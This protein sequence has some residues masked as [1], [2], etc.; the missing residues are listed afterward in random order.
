MIRLMTATASAAL[1]AILCAC[2]GATPV[3]TPPGPTT[4]TAP[5]PKVTPAATPAVPDSE[6]AACIT[7][8]KTVCRTR[9]ETVDELAFTDWSLE[10]I[11]G[12]YRHVRARATYKDNLPR[13][14]DLVFVLS[15]GAVVDMLDPNDWKAQKETFFQNKSMPA[16]SPRRGWA[17]LPPPMSFT[18]TRSSA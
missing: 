1:A 16:T 17:T 7:H 8:F 5:A 4:P 18:S 14:T 10:S 6:K 12:T 9:K 11:G 13:H 3:A 2:G 15:S